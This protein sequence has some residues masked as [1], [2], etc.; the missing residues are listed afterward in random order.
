MTHAEM[1]E[2]Y[3]LYA[4][5]VLDPESTAGIEAHLAEQCPY[6]L[7]R[8]HEAFTLTADLAN[9]A[10]PVKPPPQLRERIAAS[11]SRPKRSTNRKFALVALSAACAALLVLSVSSTVSLSHLRDQADVLRQQRDELRS[12]VE[13]LSRSNTRTIQ[14]GGTEN[15][16]HGRVLANGSAGLVFVGSHLPPLAT[17]KT[18]ELWIIPAAGAPRPAGLFHANTDGDSVHVSLLPVGAEAKAVAVTIEPRA[19]SAAPTTT[20]FLVV[21]LS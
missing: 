10:E 13:I 19:G 5:G 9:V 17:D 20:P 11:V 14:F 18:Y 16:L 7:E 21:P 4:L 3:D 6:C 15:T 1:N 2:L 12:A 8:L